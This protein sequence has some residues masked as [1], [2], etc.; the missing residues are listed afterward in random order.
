MRGILHLLSLSVTGL[1]SLIVLPVLIA[2]ADG[3]RD[4]ALRMILSGSLIFFAACCVLVAL[5]GFT[6]PLGRAEGYTA[7]IAV[8]L[9]TPVAGAISLASLTDA[10]FIDSWFEAVSALTTSGV[11]LLARDSLPRSVL[12]WRS[13]MEWY[14]GFLTL[15]SIIHVLAPG[16]FGGLP[17]GDR[18]LL[19]SSSGHSL[20][21]LGP[22]REIFSQYVLLT[23][24]L[25]AA[26]MPAGV[27][28]MTA[29]MLAMIGMATGGFLPF[30]G[31]LEDH[32]GPAAQIILGCG[33]AIGTV[34]IFWRRQLLRGPG[35]FLRDNLEALIVA[36][37]VVALT[38][39]YAARLAAV[40]GGPANPSM[41][42]E[43]FLAGVSLVSTS[44]IESRPGVIAL[45][46]DMIVLTVVLVG[47]GIY[48][49]T[50]GLKI[51]R[52]GAMG[53]HAV[54][55][56]NRLIYP[57]ISGSLYF[58]TYR[59]DEDSLR[60]V[61]SAVV[62]SLLVVIAGAFFFTLEAA[63]FEAGMALSVAL[64]SNAGPVYE[65]VTPVIY[66][67]EP[68]NDVWPRIAELP[69]VTK[70]AGIAIMT[71][72]RLEVLVVFAVLNPRF[73]LTR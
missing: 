10:G 73:W 7:L 19:L 68:G 8:W 45:M 62:L 56:L 58:G 67:A 65:A 41:F 17:G 50:G 59:L 24:I 16:G 1:A 32:A 42:A 23:L 44:G 3:E 66:T 69:V 12:F 29:A 6:R 40:S 38:V 26:L 52:L 33:L 30:E 20:S 31:A 48:S 21:E 57:S 5:S 47:A 39:A 55:E 36:V 46:P 70:L 71:L 15:V 35:S 27:D 63:D 37:V 2:V 53:A 54:R 72:G 43:A 14:G 9:A 4:L 13:M 60:A 61:W 51:Y 25:F 49:T 34:S 28:G 64:F 11:T 22:L 18:R